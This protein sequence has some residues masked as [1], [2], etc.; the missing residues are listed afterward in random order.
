MR[1][2]EEV[3]KC[4][5]MLL[6]RSVARNYREQQQLAGAEEARRQRTKLLGQQVILEGYHRNRL[7]PK[8]PQGQLPQPRNELTLVNL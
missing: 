4:M 3:I 7:R 8:Y 5:K 2:P 6:M 1:I